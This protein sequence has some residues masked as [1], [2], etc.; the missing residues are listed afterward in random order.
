MSEKGDQ[1]DSDGISVKI[2]KIEKPNSIKLDKID[3]KAKEK[4]ENKNKS[5]PSRSQ[6]VPNEVTV[7]LVIKP[8]DIQ[9]AN[10]HTNTTP[11]RNRN[12][13]R[14]QRNAAAALSNE[15]HLDAH[16]GL[17]RGRESGGTPP[18]TQ[19]PSKKA[20]TK[21]SKKQY[22][23]MPPDSSQN[24]L[25]GVAPKVAQSD[26]LSNATKIN[27]GQPENFSAQSTAN[28]ND[29]PGSSAHFDTAQTE[30]KE[31]PTANIADT[32]ADDD[33]LMDL[34]TGVQHL[35]VESDAATEGDAA[36]GVSDDR[37]QL[38]EQKEKEKSDSLSNPNG[39]SSSQPSSRASYSGVTATGSLIVAIIDQRQDDTMTLLDQYRYNKLRSIISDKVLSQAEKKKPL[40]RIVDTRLASGAMKIHCS[41]H[42]TRRWLVH[43]MTTIQTRELWSG[44]KLKVI[45]FGDLP[46]P[47][48]FQAWFPGIQKSAMDIFKLIE[49]LNNGIS[50]KSWSVLNKEYK[51]G[52]T[53]MVIGVGSESFAP[54]MKRDQ[55]ILC[56]MGVASFILIKGCPANKGAA[57][58]D[59]SSG[60]MPANDLRNRIKN[61]GRHDKLK[62]HGK[63][64]T[65]RGPNQ[66]HHGEGTSKQ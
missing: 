12:R 58:R 42:N 47:H 3:E 64:T 50:T 36:T 18:N 22:N 63:K 56:G 60:N 2:G 51:K 15:H 20:A 65:E 28:K 32:N 29:P 21:A 25:I 62:H 57:K 49:G 45:D 7:P 44:A 24:R 41:D 9:A 43:C 54:L 8:K 52:G 5:K 27:V 59:N 11:T 13:R 16:G 66:Q 6:P 26:I 53:S 33:T 39:E 38:P 14:K 48:K 37:G 55:Q 46:K 17:K 31:I 10:Q 1:S 4:N 35:T 23:A 61:A 19:A 30:S 40:P 34:S